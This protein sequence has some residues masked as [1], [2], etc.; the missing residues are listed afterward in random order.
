MSDDRFLEELRAHAGELRYQPSDAAYARLAARVRARI[1]ERQQRTVSQLLAGWF[2][3][4]GLTLAAIALTTS[5]GMAWVELHDTPSL[6][7]ISAASLDIDS[8]G[9]H[10]S[11]G[12]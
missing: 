5:V 6:D 3:P 9:E 8:G 2:R 12:E 7:S 1:A 11:V 4:V 10:Y